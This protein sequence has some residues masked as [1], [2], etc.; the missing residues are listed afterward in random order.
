M[1]CFTDDVGPVA[2]LLAQRAS[3]NV[4]QG[5]CSYSMDVLRGLAESIPPMPVIISERTNFEKAVI[6]GGVVWVTWKVFDSNACSY[7]GKAFQSLVPG[8]RWIKRRIGSIEKVFDPCLYTQRNMLESRRSGSDES[9]M[10]TPR[11]QVQVGFKRD[12]QL[13]I[14]GCAVRFD[15]NWLIAPDHVIGGE[16]VEAKY[17][18]GSNGSVVSLAGKERVLL[19]TDLSAVQLTEGE[20]ARLGVSVCK[21]APLSENGSFGQIVGPE[22]KGTT[23][24][25]K[26]DPTIFGRVTYSGTT[27]GGYSG[28][29][30]M[31]GSTVIGL[32]QMGGLINGGYSASFA[33]CKLNQHLNRSFE[34]SEQWLLGQFMAGNKLKW[35]EYSDPEFVQVRVGGLYST[36]TRKAMHAAFGNNWTANNDIERNSH[37][38]SYGDYPEY[39]SKDFRKTALE[40]Q[41][42]GVLNMSAVQESSKALNVQSL[43][44]AYAKLS[45]TQQ[46]KFRKSASLSLK[47]TISTDGQVSTSVIQN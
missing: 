30:Y 1:A 36:V 8:Y 29:A 37:K 20:F 19:D 7:I 14:I 45:P 41:P 33:W 44:S 17:A 18:A 25:L 26:H 9:I 11:C 24:T 13:V 46:K 27:L 5:V 39:E 2:F 22:S 38:M 31:A 12:A 23:G 16:M 28:A 3:R 40:S 4:R 47:P 21:I 35:T 15:G 6:V 34:S 32:H 42:P 10:T 43:M